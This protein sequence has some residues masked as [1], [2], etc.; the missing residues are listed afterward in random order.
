MTVN[1]CHKSPVLC[2]VGDDVQLEFA[3]G[4]GK[5]SLASEMTRFV[6]AVN[7]ENGQGSWCPAGGG[8]ASPASLKLFCV[9]LPYTPMLH[10]ISTLHYS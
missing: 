4:R 8:L 5:K 3:L 2:G 7:D 6:R 10:P 9:F 1:I